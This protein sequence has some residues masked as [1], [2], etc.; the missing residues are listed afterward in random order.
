MIRILVAGSIQKRNLR[1]CEPDQ[2]LNNHL[3]CCYLSDPLWFLYPK[4]RHTVVLSGKLTDTSGKGV[5]G[6]AGSF[7]EL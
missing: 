4:L 1:C 6:A 2:V 3:I 7:L 5:S